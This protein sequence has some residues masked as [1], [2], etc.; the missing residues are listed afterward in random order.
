ML[1]DPT[2]SNNQS[3][4]IFAWMIHSTFFI[5]RTQI[6]DCAP[7]IEGHLHWCNVMGHYRNPNQN[8]YLVFSHSHSNNNKYVWLLSR[9]R[10]FLFATLSNTIRS[11]NKDGRMTKGGRSNKTYGKQNS[12]LMDGKK[13]KDNA[14]EPHLRNVSPS[15]LC[16]I[17]SR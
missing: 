11:P 16:N 17:Q 4:W 5:K 3:I 9:K 1:S 2:A 7:T 10:L 15:N 14:Q 13:R 12:H 8:T 6:L